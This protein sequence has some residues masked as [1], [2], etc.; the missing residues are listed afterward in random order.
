MNDCAPSKQLSSSQ[1]WAHLLITGRKIACL[2]WCLMLKPSYS[3][4]RLYLVVMLIALSLGKFSRVPTTIIIADRTQPTPQLRHEGWYNRENKYD[5]GMVLGIQKHSNW[6][7]HLLQQ[8]FA[9][10][11]KA[12]L[13]LV[14]LYLKLLSGSTL[15]AEKSKSHCIWF[16]SWTRLQLKRTASRALNKMG[17]FFPKCFCLP[18]PSAWETALPSW[19]TWWSFCIG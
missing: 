12:R 18:A 11:L 15:T 10:S 1:I 19:F 2:W 14:S 8:T 7:I 5:N 4:N 17:C 9:I 6:F 16:P 3:P 13:F